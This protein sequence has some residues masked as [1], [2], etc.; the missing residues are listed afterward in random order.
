[1]NEMLMYYGLMVAVGMVLGAVFFGGLWMTVKQM[2]T[3]KSP[4]LL[5]MAS[6]VLRS[7]V[8]LAGF[9]YFGAGNAMAMGA[10]LLGF[11]GMRLLSTHGTAV[12]G[13]AF[14]RKE[15]H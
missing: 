14:G 4:G 10:C 2:P 11:I 5:F 8:V 3:S 15:V 7:A 9:W 13:A 12:L 1:M 6:V